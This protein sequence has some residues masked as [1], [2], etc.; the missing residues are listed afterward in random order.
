MELTLTTESFQ[1]ID[2]CPFKRQHGHGRSKRTKALRDS[3]CL[4]QEAWNSQRLDST[5]VVS[6]AGDRDTKS[7][8]A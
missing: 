4:P 3:M 8:P 5:G 1:Q 2:C 6:R 7:A